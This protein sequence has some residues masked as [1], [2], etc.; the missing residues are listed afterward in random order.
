MAPDVQTKCL[1]TLSY[2]VSLQ[3]RRYMD[4]FDQIVRLRVEDLQDPNILD[5]KK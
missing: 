3:L 4:I 5:L 1:F 2:L